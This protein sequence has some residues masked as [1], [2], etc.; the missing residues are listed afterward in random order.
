M[1]KSI[2]QSPKKA[3]L[4][5]GGTMAV[6]MLLVGS[7]DTEGALVHAAASIESSTTTDRQQDSFVPTAQRQAPQP[8]QFA[9]QNEVVEWADEDFLIDEA[10]GFD[11]TPEEFD[12]DE[13]DVY[14]TEDE[15]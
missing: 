10:S 4:F 11:P 7:E 14:L 6:V 15:Y 3:G 2:F 13:G 5:V 12:P 1:S 8:Q 9:E